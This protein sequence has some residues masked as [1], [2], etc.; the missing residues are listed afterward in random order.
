MLSLNACMCVHLLVLV[1]AALLSCIKHLSIY[2]EEVDVKS[3]AQCQNANQYNALC[4]DW[5]AFGQCQQ[6][7]D[8]M[9]FACS[10]SCRFCQSNET[11]T[12]KTTATPVPTTT[13]TTTTTTIPPTTTEGKLNQPQTSTLLSSKPIPQSSSPHWIN[14]PHLSCIR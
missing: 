14:L 10:K 2:V 7:E 12:T 11:T 4:D 13:T 9:R 1:Y 5:A 8:F 6:S 3:D